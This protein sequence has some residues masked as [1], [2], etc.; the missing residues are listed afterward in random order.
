MATDPQGFR[1]SIPRTVIAI[2]SG[3]ARGAGGGEWAE[4]AFALPSLIDI[5]VGLRATRHTGSIHRTDV[6]FESSHLPLSFIKIS[7]IH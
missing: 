4:V 5:A 1:K 6:H 2:L 7:G 3:L